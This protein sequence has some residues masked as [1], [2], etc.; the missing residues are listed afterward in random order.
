[1]QIKLGDLFPEDL[2]K[3]NV[4]EFAFI[5]KK[6]LPLQSKRQVFSA[7]KDFFNIKNTSPEE[8]SQAFKKIL[9]KADVY[10]I[11]TIAFSKRYELL[12]QGQET[13]I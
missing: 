3:A 7:I 1:M 10:Q 13:K 12:L 4:P 5:I 11:C 9:Y 6:K 8:T 2:K